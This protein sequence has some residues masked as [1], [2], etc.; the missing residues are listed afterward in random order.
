MPNEDLRQFLNNMPGPQLTTTDVAEYLRHLEEDE[1]WASSE[2]E[3]QAGCLAI[4]QREKAED[5]ELSAILSLLRDYCHEQEVRLDAERR[6]R[7]QRSRDEER[8]ARER[9]LQSGAPA[10]GTH[11]VCALIIRWG[12]E[13]PPPSCV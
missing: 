3:L 12:S 1:S 9:R 2:K 11:G 5:T 4:Y 7:Y 10:Q 6:Q 13:R 8:L